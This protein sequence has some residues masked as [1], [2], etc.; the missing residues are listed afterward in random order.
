M[1]DRD[2]VMAAAALAANREAHQFAQAATIM[3]TKPVECYALGDYEPMSDYIYVK[4]DAPLNRTAE[5]VIIAGGKDKQ[6]TAVILAMSNRVMGC[7]AC[8]AGLQ[9]SND[10]LLIPCPVC[11]PSLVL[12]RAKVGDRIMCA[13]IF[14]FEIDRQ[15]VFVVREADIIGLKVA[16]PSDA[17]KMAE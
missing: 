7:C 5:G 4:P 14:T 16:K 10:G 13:K 11:K 12:Q 1:K 6:D 2:T 15:T 17:L 8:E 3:P 9:K